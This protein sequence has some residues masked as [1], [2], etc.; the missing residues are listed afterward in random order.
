MR[1]VL[2]F[3]VVCCL[4]VGF[5]DKGHAQER[6]APTPGIGPSAAQG[7]FA[8]EQQH[9]KAIL[10]IYISAG[11][12]TVEKDAATALEKIGSPAIFPLQQ[13]LEESWNDYLIGEKPEDSLNNVKQ[14]A[15]LL[16]RFGTP[17]AALGA[18]P[19]PGSSPRALRNKLRQKLIEIANAENLENGRLTECRDA[20]QEA[21][22]ALGKLHSQKAAYLV[23]DH[24]E[25]LRSIDNTKDL[26]KR[27]RNQ[28]QDLK[29]R[30]V[31]APPAPQEGWGL[32][33]QL[34]DFPDPNIIAEILLDARN[35]QR[36]F[37]SRSNR[38]LLIFFSELEPAGKD[39]SLKERTDQALTDLENNLRIAA[40]GYDAHQQNV[41]AVK[42]DAWLRANRNAFDLCEDMEYLYA[43]LITQRWE[44]EHKQ[45][46]EVLKALNS[47]LEHRRNQSQVEIRLSVLEATR[48]MYA[49]DD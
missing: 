30:F 46:D 24:S 42:R 40:T 15:K 6:P 22:K 3:V 14:I 35:L 47:I 9:A 1:P 10:E 25:V 45:I 33:Q 13:K 29:A 49:G 2:I 31:R 21:I 4:L 8:R 28:A 44:D 16:G 32:K 7:S 39:K 34:L 27:L 38:K 12:K 36:Y 26:A 19:E 48:R 37:N 41:E 18:Y 23:M 5:A 20:R 17:F 43:E 11:S